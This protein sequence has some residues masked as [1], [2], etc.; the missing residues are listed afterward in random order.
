[1]SKK[2]Y[3]LILLALILVIVLIS[4][5]FPKNL[6]ATIYGS[7]SGEIIAEDTGE[8]LED[9]E[10]VLCKRGTS[11]DFF[12]LDK[13]R[14]DKSGKAYFNMLKEGQYILLFITVPNSGYYADTGAEG[15]NIPGRPIITLEKG[16]HIEVRR[17]ALVG[18][19]VLIKIR[20][21]DGTKFTPPPEKSLKLLAVG[22]EWGFAEL[23]DEPE[24]S[25]EY[26]TKGI[27]PDG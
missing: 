16:K 4:L 22:D 1:M 21:R 6:E 25:G 10:V 15:I 5:F 3:S 17:K 14:T 7:I 27:P 2:K 24:E 12:L 11:G 13:R 23:P 19:S 26:F 20:K 18:G 8:G 9:V